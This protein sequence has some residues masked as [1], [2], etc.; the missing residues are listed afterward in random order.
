MSYHAFSVHEKC[1]SYLCRQALQVIAR[2]RAREAIAAA[3]Q[4]MTDM[5]NAL[6]E[7]LLHRI[8][9]E[10]Y[11]E[12]VAES[13]PNFHS[14]THMET[15]SGLVN[16]QD[17]TEPQN[18]PLPLSA[19]L[20]E[21]PYVLLLITDAAGNISSF[22]WHACMCMCAAVLQYSWSDPG[23]D[24]FRGSI[25]SWNEEFSGMQVQILVFCAA[26]SRPHR[27]TMCIKVEQ[28]I[29]PLHGSDE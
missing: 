11:R 26:L 21:D 23:A 5:S 7:H 6:P 15:L 24:Y 28:N 20:G 14:S 16:V 27:A 17:G 22:L 19:T 18:R 3:A 1:V 29:H 25:L 4:R 10:E 8:R 2:R 12:E 9:I 13:S